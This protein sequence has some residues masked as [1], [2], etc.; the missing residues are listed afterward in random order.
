MPSS[1]AH[2]GGFISPN[3][4]P[5]TQRLPLMPASEEP[6]FV[7]SKQVI[8]VRP[9]RS[10]RVCRTQSFSASYPYPKRPAFRIVRRQRAI[11]P[12]RERL[13]PTPVWNATPPSV[14]TMQCRQVK[15]D[16][17]TILTVG[18]YFRQRVLESLVCAF[19]GP[20]D[21]PSLH[22]PEFQLA[23]ATRTPT[24]TLS[25]ITTAQKALTNIKFGRAAEGTATVLFLTSSDM[26][27]VT[28]HIYKSTVPVPGRR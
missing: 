15:T 27:G 22:F 16:Q 5:E 26:G 11:Q 25:T 17:F 12:R 19:D 4:G 13:L 28:G 1:A 9:H 21:P 18:K 7:R 3:R 20:A 2:P 23:C 14:H 24:R 10:R 6:G 8:R